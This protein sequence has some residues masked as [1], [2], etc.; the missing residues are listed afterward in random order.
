MVFASLILLLTGQ[1]VVLGA[2]HP[3]LSPDGQMMAFSYRGDIWTAATAGG[4]ATRLTVNVDHDTRP[5]FSPDGKWIAFSSNRTGGYDVYVMPAGGG[6]PR[7]LTFHSALDNVV[8]WTPDGKAVLFLSSRDGERTAV[9]SVDVETGATHKLTDEKYQSC[10][11]AAMAPD[12]RSIAVMRG[13]ASVYRKRYMG[14]GQTDIWLYVVAEKKYRKLTDWEG[15]DNFPLWSADGKS[16]VYV[17]E[18]S[19]SFNL[20]RKAIASGAPQKLTAFTKGMILNPCAARNSGDLVFEREGRLWLMP[21]GGKTAPIDLSCP[22]DDKE[23]TIER[24][25]VSGGAGDLA[26]SPDGAKA[27]FA[28]HGDL[29]TVGVEKGGEAK[30]LTRTDWIENH[31]VWSPDGKRIAFLSDR[32]GYPQLWIMDADGKNAK[33]LTQGGARKENMRFSPDG[34]TLF[35]TYGPYSA[36]LFSVLANG[37]PERKIDGP[38]VD[39]YAVSPDGKWLVYARED[40]A[41]SSDLMLVPTDL[42]Q[43]PVNITRRPGENGGVQWTSDGKTLVYTYRP[44]WRRGLDTAIY[45]LSLEKPAENLDEDEPEKKEEKKDEKKPVQIDLEDIH[46]RSKPIATLPNQGGGFGLSPDGKTVIFTA[47]PDGTRRFYAVGT[48]GEG[49]RALAPATAVAD[50]QFAKDP[51][52]AFY[53]GPGGAIRSIGT[54]GS[55]GGTSFSADLRVDH[56]VETRT[57]FNEAFHALNDYFYDPSLHGAE[58]DALRPFYQSLVEQTVTP[59]DLTYV[60]NQMLGELGASHLGFTIGREGADRSTGFLGVELDEA[61]SGPGARVTRVVKRTPGDKPESKL[62]SGDL[63]LEVNGETV[64][65]NESLYELLEG[66]TGKLTALRVAKD[67]GDKDSRTVKLKPI[68]GAAFGNALYEN[69]VDE[70]REMVAKASGGKLFYMHIRSMDQTSLDRFE[71]E[72]WGDAQNYAGLVLDVRNNGGGHID[73]FLIAALTRKQYARREYRGQE[74]EKPEPP[75]VW[76]RPVVL[77]TNEYSASN[78]EIFADAFRTLKLGKIVGMPT[79][80]SVIGT[81]SRSLYDGRSS[82]RIPFVWW[83][84]MD[85][86][87]MENSAVVPDIIVE[88]GPEDLMS[89]EDPQLQRA[90]KVLMEG[91]R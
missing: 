49:L 70:R 22:S 56:E 10:Y 89:D 14:G 4:V 63:I 16:V 77:L 76:E 20:F 52:K 82:I 57:M 34:K 90:V 26:V 17:S 69:W 12:G 78:S 21:K 84:R 60:M 81:S 15:Q 67:A 79:S 68:S 18:R 37:G 61:Y 43:P 50:L 39:S 66:T 30:A 42:S 55:A 47:A 6:K 40:P 28:L 87:T 83:R 5:Q 41:E 29:F 91:K 88:P 38:G 45:A 72:L 1:P 53:I 8:D 54:D 36:K 32:D 13:A 11:G 58:W 35:Y 86:S 71:R 73:E 31:P 44:T 62:A 7:R 33:P 65:H 27:A 51:K 2:H 59:E 24:K 23:N 3:G 80:A 85:G 25:S 64:K 19:G 74:R 46:T 48:D 75:K 9:N